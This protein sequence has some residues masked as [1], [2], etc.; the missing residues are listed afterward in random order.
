MNEKIRTLALTAKALRLSSRYD[1]GGQEQPFIENEQELAKFAELVVRRVIS[2]YNDSETFRTSEFDDQ[3]VLD[4]F[5][6][7]K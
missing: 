2:V 6:V 7:E 4:Y 3:R 5:G 1:A